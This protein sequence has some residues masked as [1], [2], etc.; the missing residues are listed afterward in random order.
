MASLNPRKTPECFLLQ[1]SNGKFTVVYRGAIDD[2]AQS[3]NE[4]DHHYLKAAIEKLLAKQKIEVP[5]VRPVG[6]S[7]PKN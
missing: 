5:D 1:Q 6:C 7:I 2:N 3:E 4:V